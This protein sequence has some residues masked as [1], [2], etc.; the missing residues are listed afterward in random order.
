MPVPRRFKIVG[1]SYIMRGVRSVY[2]GQ[3]H[4]DICYP[5]SRSLAHRLR[6]PTDYTSARRNKFNPTSAQ[7]CV[8]PRYSP[9]THGVPNQ[10]RTELRLPKRRGLSRRSL[11][12][13]QRRPRARKQF[14]CSPSLFVFSILMDVCVVVLAKNTI[15]KNIF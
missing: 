15:R 11:A 10:R 9:G 2:P 5:V 4:T 12:M 8:I 3:Q 7:H 13:Q 1:Q 14:H 6:P